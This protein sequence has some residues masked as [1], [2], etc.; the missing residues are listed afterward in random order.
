MEDAVAVALGVA[1]ASAWKRLPFAALPEAY[2]AVESGHTRG[3]VV[4]TLP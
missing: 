2:A 3:K 1:G 4:V